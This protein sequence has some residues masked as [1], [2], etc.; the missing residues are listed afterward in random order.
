M[1][2][3]HVV[4]EEHRNFHPAALH[5]SFLERPLLRTTDGA[6][7]ASDVAG[8][9]LRGEPQRRHLRTEADEPQLAELFRQRHLPEHIGDERRLVAEQGGVRLRH[10]HWGGKNDEETPR[11]R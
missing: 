3:Y 9:D 2:M 5:G 4:R 11:P 10:H 7:R 1:A 6:E 8:C